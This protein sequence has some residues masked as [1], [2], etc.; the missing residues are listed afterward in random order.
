MVARI[1]P[2][3]F[4]A[5]FLEALGEELCALGGRVKRREPA[6]LYCTV[7]SVVILWRYKVLRDSKA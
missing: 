5:C 7:L 1:P 2:R 4:A 6:E 3:R